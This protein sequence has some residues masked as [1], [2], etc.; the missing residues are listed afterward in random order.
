MKKFFTLLGGLLIASNLNVKAEDLTVSNHD[1]ESSVTVD[2]KNANSYVTELTKDADGNWTL[3]DFLESGVPF[4]FKFEK[5][6]AVGDKAAITITS[7]FK[8]DGDYCYLLDSD[9]KSIQGKIFNYQG[10]GAEIALFDPYIYNTLSYS[11]VKSLDAATDGY[12]YKATFTVRATDENSK[13]YT[14]YLSFSF[15]EPQNGDTSSASVVSVENAPVEYFNLQ[16][17]KMA[18]P[19][20]GIFIRKQGS[21]TSKVVIR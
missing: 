4:S 2:I 13:S 5:P 16:G 6:E 14:L 17:V 10:K 3:A 19:S 20:N 21:K 7:N 8:A 12:E 11:Y 15:N 18:D 9:D 1:E